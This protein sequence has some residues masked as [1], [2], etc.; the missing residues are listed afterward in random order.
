[1]SRAYCGERAKGGGFY[2]LV[3]ARTEGAALRMEAVD[4]TGAVF[5]TFSAPLLR[6][7]KAR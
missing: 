2:H 4:D 6:G 1:M 7:P 3:R 5:D